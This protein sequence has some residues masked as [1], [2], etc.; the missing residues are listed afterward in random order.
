MPLP[1]WVR[2]TKWTPAS[3]GGGS[4]GFSVEC[5]ATGELGH[6]K[7]QCIAQEVLASLLADEIGVF[8]PETRLGTCEEKT[9]AVSKLWGVKSMDIPSLRTTSPQV[10]SSDAFKAALRQTSGLL[11][12]HAWLATS[13]LKDEHVMIR[14]GRNPGTYEIASIDF[15]SAF[16]WD[17]SGGGV[18]VPSAPPVLVADEHRDTQI[19]S[20]TMAR[21]EAIADNHIEGIVQ[22]LPEEILPTADKERIAHG[23]TVRKSTLRPVFQAAGWLPS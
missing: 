11:P 1:V 9:I 12:F 2:S 19:M 22:R 16:G 15:A 13:D 21:I 23:L 10:Y 8:V 7:P 5:P 6:A 4:Q 3:A 18:V 17:A 20:D 14:S